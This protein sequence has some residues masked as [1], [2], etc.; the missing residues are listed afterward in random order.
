MKS[1]LL[2][3]LLA[4]PLAAQS[5]LHV[6]FDDL[7]LLSSGAAH[8]TL[9]GSAVLSANNTTI[10][11]NKAASG[12]VTGVSAGIT[13]EGALSLEIS[14]D[15]AG[16]FSE[17]LPIVGLPLT[18]F[19]VADDV[20]VSPFSVLVLNVSGDA[21]F[22]LRT[23]FVQHFNVHADVALGPGFHVSVDDGPSVHLA[24]QPEIAAGSGAHIEVTATLAVVYL[25]DVGG[26]PIGGPFAGVTLGADA[27]I[28]VLGDPWWSVD[29]SMDILAGYW[30]L[31]IA[32]LVF[33]V[34]I[35]HFGD[36]GGPLAGLPPS[37][38]WARCL[39]SD[40]YDFTQG[41]V[42][43]PGGFLLSGRRSFGADPFLA[44]IGPDGALLSAE[45]STFASNGS[46]QKVVASTPTSDGG[47]VQAGNGATGVR[48][49]RLDAGGVMLWSKVYAHGAA[50]LPGVVD[51]EALPDG[52]FACVAGLALQAS[53]S[54][55]RAFVLRV[56]ADGQLL[57]AKDLFLGG[58]DPSHFV[59]DLAATA[60]GS[61]LLAG[62]VS[63]SEMHGSE[64]ALFANNLLLARLE[65]DG[66]LAFAEVLGSIGNE[67]GTSVAEGPDGRLWVGGGVT[68]GPSTWAW[69]SSFGASGAL[70]S[71]IKF[72]GADT[73][74]FSVPVRA[75][76]PVPGGVRLLG[77][78]GLGAGHDAW[79]ALVS[80]GGLPLSWTG[81]GGPGEDAPLGLRALPDGLLAWGWTQSLN[82][83]GSGTGYDHW[84]L[85]T[86]VDGLLHF[87]AATGFASSAEPID[88][89]YPSNEMSYAL[90]LAPSLQPATITVS[91]KPLPYVTV[92]AME[93]VL[94]E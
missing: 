76:A 16:A 51:V 80:D 1:L 20:N 47:L 30:G 93:T 90:L 73:G 83:Q 7:E 36:A 60:D 15:A 78:R 61:L 40:G 19:T 92:A 43:T 35:T 72:R 85:R 75:L 62:Y 42:P 27:D 41:V 31:G 66:D 48:L 59:R 53:S 52:G 9:N 46:G 69:L 17:T 65:P 74:I 39:Q 56:D 77:D 71:S 26:L 68:E 29:G 12:A 5:A 54:V 55:S 6:P 50:F 3:L 67:Q 81:L 8:V 49:D 33:P 87:D 63:Y 89:G 18:G 86:S 34:G 58:P 57:W 32:P 38:R 10:T 64:M 84:L 88:W 25:L 13:L 23:S 21:A 4:A 82:A 79:L 70:A 94:T 14:A 24:G 2:A 28:D 37:T 22:G 11:V 91:D 44:R 45:V